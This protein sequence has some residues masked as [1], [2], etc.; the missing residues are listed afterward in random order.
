ME[1]DPDTFEVS[2]IHVFRSEG[3][4]KGVASIE[5]KKW[6]MKIDN[7]TWKI[8]ERN[9]VEVKLPGIKNMGEKK[10]FCPL[11]SFG[12]KEAEKSIKR[13]VRAAIRERLA[14]VNQD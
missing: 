2:G 6:G 11:I 3:S 9:T 12:N 1:E 4:T 7:I 14:E 5:L 13:V 10:S 8:S